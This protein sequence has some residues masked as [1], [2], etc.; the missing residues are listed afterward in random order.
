MFYRYAGMSPLDVAVSWADFR[1][2]DIVKARVDSLPPIDPKKKK[3]AARRSASPKRADALPKV[4][5]HC[6][7]S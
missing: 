7:I 6:I 4:C 3:N 5:S 2:F 1:V